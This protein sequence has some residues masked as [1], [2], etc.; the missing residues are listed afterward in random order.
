MFANPVANAVG[1]APQ[2]LVAN[3]FDGDG[4]LDFVTSGGAD[5]SL[6]VLLG[7]GKALLAPTVNH[8]T[9]PNTVWVATGDINGDKKVDIAAANQNGNN[10]SILL[11]NF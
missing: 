2:S 3:D 7:T 11:N 10:I 1:A 8:D 9:G 4:K 6:S 5:R